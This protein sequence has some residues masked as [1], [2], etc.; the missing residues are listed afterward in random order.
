MASKYIGGDT[1]ELKQ[2]SRS[3][4]ISFTMGTDVCKSPANKKNG[5][6]Q[7][8]T[9]KC[10]ERTIA[11]GEKIIKRAMFAQTI[12]D[13]ETK[14]NLLIPLMGSRQ[15]IQNQRITNM[16]SASNEDPTKDLCI[17]LPNLSPALFIS[18]F[19]SLVLARVERNYQT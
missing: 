8:K 4:V 17:Y 16:L 6:K 7:L 19:S 10:F 3:A 2:L 13:N 5:F 15:V 11:S 14:L 12:R 1:Y 9:V 18:S